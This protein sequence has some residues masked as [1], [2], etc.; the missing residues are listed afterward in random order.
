VIERGRCPQ[1]GVGRMTRRYPPAP[2]EYS[3]GHLD[4]MAPV[5]VQEYEQAMDAPPLPQDRSET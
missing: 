4:L 5:T 1:C 2:A 3:C